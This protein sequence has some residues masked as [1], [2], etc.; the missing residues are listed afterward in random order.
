[1][2][3]AIDE[4]QRRH[5]NLDRMMCETL[6]KLHEQG[7]LDAFLPNWIQLRHTQISASIKAQSRSKNPSPKII[8]PIR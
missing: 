7:K 4:L 2:E 1:M 3:L 5:L 8:S 6:F